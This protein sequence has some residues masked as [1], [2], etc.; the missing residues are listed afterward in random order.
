MMGESL[1]DQMW[2]LLI[3]LS[4]DHSAR[5]MASLMAGSFF[6][7]CIS[8][9]FHRNRC[10]YFVTVGRVSAIF[11]YPVK[12]CRWL[13]VERA[14]CTRLGISYKDVGDR[15]WMF[16]RPNNAFLSQRQEPKMSLITPNVDEEDCLQLEA[17]EMK[18][19]RLPKKSKNQNKNI[20][21]C[22]V[23]G[24]EI[25]GQDCGDEAATWICDYLQK[26]GYRMVYSGDNLEK[27]N[28]KPKQYSPIQNAQC[29]YQDSSPYH[30]LSQASI[31]DINSRINKEV[32]VYNFR[33][34]I[35][36]EGCMAFDEDCWDEIRIGTNV[37]FHYIEPCSR[38]LL[39]S[40]EPNTGEKDPEME[41]FKTLQS[42]RAPRGTKSPNFGIMISPNTEGWI[43]VGDPV[44]AFR[45]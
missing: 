30:L 42:F 1:G 21:L 18:P 39:P 8:V 9:W 31:D 2:H 37:T 7:H 23:W 45:K 34:N 25:S 27:R 40:V 12:S 14:W 16:V 29:V 13:S 15:Q 22:S 41:P 35:L 44:Y 20:I 43:Q 19:L 33:P 38:C 24:N 10:N 36:V 26:D 3:S 4:E 11:C 32:T 6:K 17:P 5:V 28:V